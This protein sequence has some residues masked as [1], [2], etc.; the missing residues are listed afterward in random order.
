MAADPSSSKYFWQQIYHPTWKL[1][2]AG[3]CLTREIWRDLEDAAFSELSVR[4]IRVA[5][6][7]T[8]IEP[9]IMGFAVK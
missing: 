5:L 1:L 7:W 4:H 6:P 3:C 8:P 2:F 9:H